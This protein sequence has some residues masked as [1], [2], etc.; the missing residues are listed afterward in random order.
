MEKVTTVLETKGVA[1]RIPATPGAGIVLVAVLKGEQARGVPL[2]DVRVAGMDV[3]AVGRA[4]RRVL[5]GAL[6]DW[7]HERGSSSSRKSWRQPG[8]MDR[9]RFVVKPDTGWRQ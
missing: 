7:R 4:R 1:H 9:H 5:T 8:R 3:Y 6:E 2:L